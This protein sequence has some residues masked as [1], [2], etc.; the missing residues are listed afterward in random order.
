MHG[1]SARGVSLTPPLRHDE[2]RLVV[3]LTVGP[4]G[5]FRLVVPPAFDKELTQQELT[6]Q[7]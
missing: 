3:W 4:G 6:D 1:G 7:D 2:L 5:K